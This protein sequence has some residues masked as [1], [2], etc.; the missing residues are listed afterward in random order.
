[1]GH[2]F[3][4][5]YSCWEF[6]TTL[7]ASTLTFL[8]IMRLGWDRRRVMITIT[9]FWLGILK[10]ARERDAQRLTHRVYMGDGS[11]KMGFWLP[12]K[13]FRLIWKISCWA[14]QAALP[15]AHQRKI[16]GF[17]PVNGK[18]L[19]CREAVSMLTRTTLKA[20]SWFGYLV[21]R[22]S[23]TDGT[24]SGFHEMVWRYVYC[25]I[26]APFWLFTEVP[27]IHY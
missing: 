24:K 19:L 27:A 3:P 18:H 21:V 14:N 20:G 1:M 2:N 13:T 10:R 22:D 6:W 4:F 15:F 17:F 8:S 7:S 23:E 26:W 25:I 16:S 12:L 9:L 5:G 11:A